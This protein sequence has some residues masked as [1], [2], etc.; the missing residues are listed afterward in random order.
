M[1]SFTLLFFAV[2]LLR[3]NALVPALHA[4]EARWYRSNASGLA[5][6]PIPS[7]LAALRNE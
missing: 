2:L 6:E 5:L 3:F 1:R 7:R 4:E